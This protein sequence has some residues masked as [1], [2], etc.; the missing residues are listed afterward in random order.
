MATCIY[1]I[2][3]NC[4]HNCEGC[5]YGRNNCKIC[6]ELIDIFDAESDMICGECRSKINL[7]REAN[8]DRRKNRSMVQKSVRNN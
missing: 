3:T 7:I 4:Y 6:S 5:F 2:G 1:D 8:N